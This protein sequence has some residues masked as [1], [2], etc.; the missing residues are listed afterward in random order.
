[1]FGFHGYILSPNGIVYIDPISL[2][3]IKNYIIYYKREIPKELFSL[4]CLMDDD[5]SVKQPY[6]SSE[7]TIAA[8]GNLRRYRLA[9][10]ATYE[11]TSR[12]GG[13]AG[14]I[15][16]MNTTLNRVN[17]IY[18]KELDI[19]LT[20]IGNNDI[21]VYTTPADPYTNDNGTAMLT[22]NASN[23][24]ALIGNSNYDIGHVFSTG[25]GGIASL[26]VVCRDTTKAQG[27]TG[28][29]NPVGD[30]FDVDYVSHEMGHQFGAFHTF[31]A[32]TGFCSNQ[33]HS[34]AAYEPG[35]GSTIMA[36]A[37][38]C[39]S[40]DLQ[41]NSDAYF[42]TK[43]YDE[44]IAYT[45]TSNG[46]LCPTVVA[47][48]NLPPVVAIPSSYNIPINTPFRL[49][50]TG[51]DPDGGTMTYCWEE[52]DLS[53]LTSTGQSWDE[54]IAGVNAPIFRSFTPTTDSQRIFPKLS[55]ILNDTVI[56]GEVRPIYNRQLKF[57]CT[58]RDNNS[59]CGGV[60]HSIGTTTINV[61][62]EIGAG[63][64]KSIPYS[65]KWPAVHPV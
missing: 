38:I 42:H 18:K 61:I 8:D 22:Q 35:S 65:G 47:S 31:N 56:I 26:S 62:D 53:G 25:G 63:F 36:Y 50:A 55:S 6:T 15:N 33:R 57:R 27:V 60:T 16:A 46:S 32:I 44:I 37:G 11:Y 43:S 7:Q 51:S 59:S 19:E 10:A 3:D 12:F 54:Q 30:P 17:G 45:Q 2:N 48:T 49:K 34:N 20:L 52:F 1:M 14:A 21:L 4:N 23:L 39:G 28:L 29:S 40:N 58:V 9:L 13:Q 5:S 24:S 41:H 64:S